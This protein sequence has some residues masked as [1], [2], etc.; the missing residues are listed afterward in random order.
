MNCKLCTRTFWIID[1]LDASDLKEVCVLRLGS[2]EFFWTFLTAS[3][4]WSLATYTRHQE[5]WSS[6]APLEICGMKV[7]HLI[8]G[9]CI[10]QSR[11][12]VSTQPRLAIH[13]FGIP[14]Q[15]AER[16]RLWLSSIY[17]IHPKSKAHTLV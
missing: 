13:T 2:L 3:I 8:V 16:P 12:S 4:A 17:Y 10:V 5:S 6:L 15:P 9:F 11:I 1:L 14:F 7:A